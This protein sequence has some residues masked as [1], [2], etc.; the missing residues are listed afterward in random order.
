LRRIG[1][2]SAWGFPS[3]GT[4][5]SRGRVALLGSILILCS[6][7]HSSSAQTVA[8]QLRGVTQVELVIEALKPA[9]AQCGIV[10]DELKAAVVYHLLPIRVIQPTPG[11]R[12][13]VYLNVSTILL[14]GTTCVSTLSMQVIKVTSYNDQGIPEDKYGKLELWHKIALLSSPRNMHSSRVIGE[15]NS[16]AQILV[17]DWRLDATR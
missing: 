6:I 1:D 14:Y 3:K 16:L 10:E 15:V 17:A 4:L 11:P 13:Y 8:N 7:A 2:A 9:D 12:P 5:A